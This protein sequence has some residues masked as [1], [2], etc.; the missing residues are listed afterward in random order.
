MELASCNHL[1]C[2]A[3]GDGIVR[4]WQCG[5]GVTNVSAH[6]LDVNGRIDCAPA[7]DSS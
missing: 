6:V 7:S 5:A 1:D 2:A 4:A 3:D